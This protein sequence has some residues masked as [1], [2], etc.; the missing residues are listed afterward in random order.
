M[1]PS[2]WSLSQLSYFTLHLPPLPALPF[3]LPLLYCLSWLINIWLKFYL[4]LCVCLSVSLSILPLSPWNVSPETAGS[5]GW[6]CSLLYPQSLGL[7]GTHSHS[8]TIWWMDRWMNKW[9]SKIWWYR[10][11]WGQRECF[12]SGSTIL[13]TSHISGYYWYSKGKIKILVNF[14]PPCVRHKALFLPPCVLLLQWLLLPPKESFVL[15]K[16]HDRGHQ[17][18]YTELEGSTWGCRF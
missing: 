1:S 7:P 3:P 13:I 4:F 14:F 9:M 10:R 16:L 17:N 11:E 2:H 18:I 5:I 15:R 8:I 6:F 12:S